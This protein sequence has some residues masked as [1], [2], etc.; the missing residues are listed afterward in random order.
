NAGDMRV[1]LAG[2][3][4]AQKGGPAFDEKIEEKVRIPGLY[5]FLKVESAQLTIVDN[6]KNEPEQVLVVETSA[7][8]SESEMQKSVQ[9]WV[10][11]VYDPNDAD[12][13]KQKRPHAWTDAAMVGEG[14]LKKP[15]KL[16]AI[17]SEKEFSTTHSFKFKADVGRYVF[18]EVRKGLRAFGG[19]V[20]GDAYVNTAKVEPFPR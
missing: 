3:T 15:I 2:G 19:Y 16:S 14:L 7:G 9:A 17:A 8:V 6:E 18:V 4:T 12:E 1:R 20:L 13:A 11:P 5:N 10:L